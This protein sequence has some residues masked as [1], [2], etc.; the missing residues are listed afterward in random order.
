LFSWFNAFRVLKYLNF[1]SDKYYPHIDVKEA[2]NTIL[3]K[4][5]YTHSEDYSEPA[6]LKLLREHE[7]RNSYS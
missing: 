1:C 6:L 5:G 7:K 4:L 3:D 2:V